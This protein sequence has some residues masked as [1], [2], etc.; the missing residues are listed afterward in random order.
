M[1]LT[2]RPVLRS[3]AMPDEK[4]GSPAILVLCG[5]AYLG[6]ALAFSYLDRRFGRF[7]VEAGW[8]I[9]WTCLGFG[10]GVLSLKADAARDRGFALAL[11]IIAGALSLFPGFLMFRLDRWAALL[12]LLFTAARAA[13][14]RSRRDFYYGLVAIVAVS[15]LVATHSNADWTTWFYLGP[16]W[17]AIAMALAWDY[18]AGVQ[19]GSLRKSVL[20]LGF[21]AVCIA[22]STAIFTMLPQPRILGFGFLP[23]GTSAPGRFQGEVSEPARAA[24]PLSAQQSGSDTPETVLGQAVQRMRQ[25]LKDPALP[26]WQRLAVQGLLAGAEALMRGTGNAD[27]PVMLRQMTAEE[28]QA[29]ANRIAAVQSFLRFIAWLLMLAL[30][31]GIV[32]LLRWRIGIV[33]ALGG[34]WA[35]VRISPSA[36]MRCSSFAIR[37]L[38]ARGGHPLRPGQSVLEHVQTAVALPAPAREW[39]ERS[40]RIYCADRFGGARASDRSAAYVRRA[41]DAARELMRSSRFRLEKT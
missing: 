25:S 34:A 36:S 35:L 24:G 5:C 6:V 26:G 33:L 10:N 37:W 12:L 41:V 19:L 16:A 1:A 39:L 23:P 28:A 38:L 31:A 21:V 17:L 32:W 40:T 7:G 13:N 9:I 30:A 11:A 14:M 27:G 15:L 4:L 18:A 8:W 2:D 20:A 22:L 3:D 29:F